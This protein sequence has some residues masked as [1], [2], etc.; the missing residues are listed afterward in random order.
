MKLN[1]SFTILNISCDKLG[2][3][4]GIVD[5]SGEPII[6]KERYKDYAGYDKGE[7]VNDEELKTVIISLFTDCDYR[8]LYLRDI[9][10]G[11]PSEFC[12]YR[13]KKAEVKFPSPIKLG[14]AEIN[15]LLDQDNNKEYDEYVCIEKAITSFV[16]KDNEEIKNPVNM[17]ASEIAG[18]ISCTF[19]DKKVL[20]LLNDIALSLDLSFI[21]KAI[22]NLMA[23]HFIP[24]DVRCEGVYLLD[25]G[26]A[27]TTVAYVK[28]D[29]VTSS[30]SFALGS[31]NVICDFI[32]VLKIGYL[33]SAGLFDV[34]DLTIKPM[35]DD[36]YTIDIKGDKFQYKAKLV[37]KIAESR[38][39]QIFDYVKRA[40]EKIKI[41]GRDGVLLL[42]KGF[43]NTP[44]IEEI[45][46]EL[47]GKN[48]KRVS[49][50][51]LHLDAPE[52]AEEIAL[53]KEALDIMPVEY[54]GKGNRLLA[55]FISKIRRKKIGK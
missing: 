26:R 49:Q 16:N 31:A 52:K 47:I 44:S 36:T 38:L 14:F 9:I 41:S 43:A 11:L 51:F 45:A 20:N 12:S 35:E 7:F 32:K 27:N 33:H 2:L 1:N 6:L 39:N 3:I 50:S 55:N 40:F 10:V 25:L 37:N 42:G 24:K 53:I 34:L 29:G 17:I 8:S 30:V 4:I 5:E 13:E 46:A 22:I 23:T 54:S 21:Y 48:V 19:A 15:S 28:G 18:N